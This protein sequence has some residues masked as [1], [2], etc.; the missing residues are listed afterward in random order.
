MI[1]IQ[2]QSNQI[3]VA[4]GMVLVV[5]V[6][7]AV[8]DPAYILD[9]AVAPANRPNLDPRLSINSVGTVAF[10]ATDAADGL[11]KVFVSEFC[12]TLPCPT[13]RPISFSGSGRLFSGA[14]I[15]NATPPVVL[16]VDRV[17]GSPPAFFLR[18]WQTATAGSFSILDS[19]K[20]Q[21]YGTFTGFHS[22]SNKG[23][24]TDAAAKLPNFTP[25]LN[26]YDGSGNPVY[27]YDFLAGTILRPQ[28][29]RETDD[30]VL[31]R[32]VAGSSAIYVYRRSAGAPRLVVDSTKGYSNLAAWPG[33]SDDGQV[34]GFSGTRAGKNEIGLEVTYDS[35]TS[36]L[37]VKTRFL[38][39]VAREGA[40]GVV[41]LANSATSR[42]SVFSRRAPTFLDP[43]SI[44]HYLH[45]VT[46][47]FSATVKTGSGPAV[48][49]VYSRD[50][51]LEGKATSS[52]SAS[53]YEFKVLVKGPILPV[54]RAGDRVG[55]ASLVSGFALSGGLASSTSGNAVTPQ[56]DVHL[57]W[58][59]L[60]AA[61]AAGKLVGVRGQ[62]AC[63]LPTKPTLPDLKQ[64]SG[65]WNSL[66]LGRSPKANAIIKAG[67]L[68]TDIS[69]L[70]A[71]SQADIAAGQLTPDRVNDL[72][73]GSAFSV[74]SAGEVK[75]QAGGTKSVG[76][77]G[78]AGGD[79]VALV[80][81]H[82]PAG[83]MRPV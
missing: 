47:A 64:F 45:A 53:K 48:E 8:A 14:S 66:V 44:S 39:V 58:I 2:R 10:A 77:T 20:N 51:V 7:I 82:P 68:L 11:S 19:T 6:P 33:I 36:I 74:S 42:V 49:G 23:I 80:T 24:A 81:A 41:S 4:A 62:R 34:I 29:A 21:T 26:L 73:K 17:S 25:S 76:L 83:I 37:P 18:E 67:C 57:P 55:S 9:L 5:Q 3:L 59:V 28:I 56:A 75:I 31:A 1:S 50:L 16:S 32:P 12:K 52:K 78:F 38:N 79:I 13:S 63:R 70:L 40:E 72:L 54:A 43:L 60:T 71:Y 27:S 65:P 15:N 69:N 61:D 30:I 22:L 35:D 46:V